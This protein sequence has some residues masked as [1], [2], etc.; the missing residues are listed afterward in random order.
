MKTKTIA[1]I[2]VVA[3]VSVVGA[4]VASADTK[5][6]VVRAASVATTSRPS[7]GGM[8]EM[9]EDNLLATVLAGLVANRTLTETQTATIKAA[10][11]AA[12]AAAHGADEDNWPMGGALAGAKKQAVILQTLNIT[13]ATL[14]DGLKAGKS[15]A[16]IAGPTKT[17][18]LIAALVA[19]ENAAIDAAVVAGKLTPAQAVTA[20]A[21]VTANVTA[22]VNQVGRVGAMGMGMGR[23]RGHN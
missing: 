14:K 5:K 12:R 17:P 18:A 16:T 11:K 13:E 2:A 8:N 4:G 22:E 1:M 9:G 10:V 23:G 15:L 20:K 19:A 21:G 3:T 7:I 6:T